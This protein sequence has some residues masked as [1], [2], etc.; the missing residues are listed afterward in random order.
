MNA[1]RRK[2]IDKL[3]AELQG[4]AVQIEELKDT[5]EST[6]SDEQEYYEAMPESLQSGDKGQ[7]AEEASGQ[8]EAAKDKLE[9]AVEAINEAVGELESAKE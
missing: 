6:A 4:L 1:D 8:L 7:R 2:T 5:V 3:I 9:E